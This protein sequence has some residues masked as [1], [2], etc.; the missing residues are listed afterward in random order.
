MYLVDNIIYTIYVYILYLLNLKFWFN[1]CH[2][3]YS[4]VTQ[5]DIAYRVAVTGLYCNY[6]VLATFLRY[7]NLFSVRD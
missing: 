6:Y 3:R 2:S 5:V 7:Y 4:A 1:P